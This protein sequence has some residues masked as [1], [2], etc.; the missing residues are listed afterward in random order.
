MTTRR[1]SLLALPV[2][3]VA[4]AVVSAFAQQGKGDSKAEQ[5]LKRRAEQFIEAF[6]RGDARAVAS[7]WTS[8]GDYVDLAGT[9]LKGRKAIEESFA[10]LFADEKGAK[11]H[12]NP[13][14]VRLASPDVAIEDG[15][16][17]VTPP[18]GGPP[19]A[20]AYM[21]VHVMKDGEWYLASVRDSEA[22]GP[23][24]FEHLRDLEWLI[25]E[26]VD[27]D[28]KGDTATVTYEWTD[29]QNFIVSNL[30]ASI[31]DVPISGRTQWIGWDAS[32]KHI[33][34]WSFNSDGGFSEAVW[35]KDGKRLTAKTTATLP[36]GKK[37]TATSIVTR[38]DDDH[39][40]WQAT[41]RMLDGK[42]LPDLEVI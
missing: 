14:S 25:G 27:E 31:K 39:V 33:R 21:A 1:M 30:V 29:N 37:T 23:S 3:L 38:I 26:W 10:K 35:S 5:A 7:F 13:T 22:K 20:S 32:A 15:I 42:Q 4:I 41:N 17:E 36:D 12:I 18:G 2:C 34:S 6:N 24:N 9:H 11:L 19:M 40:T 28:S 8:D 16:T